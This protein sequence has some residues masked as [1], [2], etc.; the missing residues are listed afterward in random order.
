[1]TLSTAVE[2]IGNWDRDR[3]KD[4]SAMGCQERF[5]ANEMQ[6]FPPCESSVAKRHFAFCLCKKHAQQRRR[7]PGQRMFEQLLVNDGKP[8][9][10]LVPDLAT[11]WFR[12]QKVFLDK[13]T[14]KE[15]LQMQLT[16]QL[17]DLPSQFK[18]SVCDC[19]RCGCNEPKVQ[20]SIQYLDYCQELRR[21]REHLQRRR[22]HKRQGELMC[23]CHNP[24]A[25]PYAKRQ[26]VSQS[27]QPLDNEQAK[28]KPESELDL[29]LE[30]KPEPEPEPEG[31][32]KA[33]KITV[34]PTHVAGC[35]PDTSAERTRFT[36]GLSVRSKGKICHMYPQR[37][38]CCLR[39]RRRKSCGCIF[40]A[41][42]QPMGDECIAACRRFESPLP[43]LRKKYSLREVPQRRLNPACFRRISPEFYGLLKSYE[44]GMSKRYPLYGVPLRCWCK[45]T[46]CCGCEQPA[47]DAC[48]QPCLGDQGLEACVGYPAKKDRPTNDSKD[49]ESSDPIE[50]LPPNYMVAP[51]CDDDTCKVYKCPGLVCTSAKC[52]KNA[53]DE[54]CES[55]EQQSKAELDSNQNDQTSCPACS[56]EKNEGQTGE[57]HNDTKDSSVPNTALLS[58]AMLNARSLVS[59]QST[60]VGVSKAGPDTV[61][62]CCYPKQWFF[63]NKIVK[64]TSSCMGEEPELKAKRKGILGSVAGLCKRVI[65]P[66]RYLLYSLSTMNRQHVTYDDL[67]LKKP[68]SSKEPPKEIVEKAKSASFFS[69]KSKSSNWTPS[70][71][72]GT[73]WHSSASCSI[74]Q[75]KCNYLKR[76]PIAGQ[77]GKIGSKWMSANKIN[78]TPSFLPHRQKFMMVQGERPEWMTQSTTDI[79]ERAMETRTPDPT[80]EQPRNAQLVEASNEESTGQP[81]AV[82]HN[83]VFVSKMS[84]TNEKHSTSQ[85]AR[86]SYVPKT[87]YSQLM[88]LVARKRPK[89]AHHKRCAVSFAGKQR[90]NGRQPTNL[91]QRQQ[92][93]S[94][95]EQH[96]SSPERRRSASPV[97]NKKQRTINQG[98]TPKQIAEPVYSKSLSSV[99]YRTNLQAPSSAWLS[100][101]SDDSISLKDQFMSCE[102]Q[103]SKNRAPAHRQAKDIPDP[104]PAD[105]N[106]QRPADR[107]LQDKEYEPNGQQ[108]SSYTARMTRLYNANTS[109]GIGMQVTNMSE[110][111]PRNVFDSEEVYSDQNLVE[112]PQQHR[113]NGPSVNSAARNAHNVLDFKSNI[114]NETSMDTVEHNAERVA[115]ITHYVQGPSQGDLKMNSIPSAQQTESHGVTNLIF[116]KRAPNNKKIINL[117]DMVLKLP[118]VKV[119]YPHCKAHSLL[120]TRRP[121][122]PPSPPQHFRVSQVKM[123][124]DEQWRQLLEQA[125]L[126]YINQQNSTRM[127]RKYGSGRY[128]RNDND[129]DNNNGNNENE[130]ENY[131][132][133]HMRNCRS[134]SGCD[135]QFQDNDSPSNPTQQMSKTLFNN[136]T[137]LG[138]IGRQAPLPR[139]RTYASS[140]YAQRAKKI[141]T[142]PSGFRSSVTTDSKMDSSSQ[143]IKRFSSSEDVRQQTVQAE[144]QSDERLKRPPVE[145]YP[146][147]P[148]VMRPPSIL[149]SE[150]L[151]RNPSDVINAEYGNR[152]IVRMSA[153]NTIDCRD[154]EYV[155]TAGRRKSDM[156]PAFSESF[157]YPEPSR[158][159]SQSSIDYALPS[160]RQA[161][162]P[163]PSSILKS[164]SRPLSNML[165]QVA[166]IRHV[167]FMSTNMSDLIVPSREHRQAVYAEGE[168]TTSFSMHSGKHR[169]AIVRAQ[170]VYKNVPHKF[171]FM[172]PKKS[173]SI[174]SPLAEQEKMPSLFAIPTLPFTQETAHIG[175]SKVYHQSSTGH[176]RLSTRTKT[177]PKQRKLEE[178]RLPT[179]SQL[180]T[181][182]GDIPKMKRVAK[183]RPMPRSVSL[184]SDLDFNTYYT[185]ARH[186]TNIKNTDLPGTTTTDMSLTLTTVLD[187]IKHKCRGCSTNSCPPTAE[188]RLPPP[189]SSDDDED[190][191]PDYKRLSYPCSPHKVMGNTQ[192]LGED[193]YPRRRCCLRRLP[194]EPI[195]IAPTSAGLRM[196]QLRQKCLPTLFYGRRC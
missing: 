179:N 29:E 121:P 33:N 54:N 162:L 40:Q 61:Q 107:A 108:Y 102:S 57:S 36:G 195:V 154:V 137:T 68:K 143:K 183:D 180:L 115:N 158:R 184:F 142:A 113:T 94:S 18:P 73:L 96:E 75:N 30:P 190:S 27:D 56:Q 26:R 134:R 65:M 150:F 104:Q 146:K 131:N 51:D 159:H 13:V 11:D 127:G 118:K 172:Q 138:F 174:E 91:M 43:R 103:E 100:A 120:S 139:P 106:D 72:Q 64:D 89:T 191:E 167:N 156:L 128:Y 85:A 112:Q 8:E 69:S 9:R 176:K 148:A 17:E 31:S 169:P 14:S 164:A 126:N 186:I 52:Q 153:N 133:G 78:L 39:A 3:A 144:D 25:W 98:D 53:C 10:L 32:S 123:L 22:H 130:N 95:K 173:K 166:D 140:S 23:D 109:H 155:H 165:K 88:H 58:E 47:T 194:E 19:K 189:S 44:D 49:T 157:G 24:P 110:K 4:S 86:A 34:C 105:L 62:R 35:M 101:Y 196:Q 45:T 59:S 15:L 129:I 182:R 92:T 163:Q 81:E 145:R 2:A 125:N 63:K 70:Q 42:G 6:N 116:S 177:T 16:K 161:G 192:D 38:C 50:E 122:P 152:A 149:T 124:D 90:V 141:Y 79:D 171:S 193:N 132:N 99:Q 7:T 37:T 48:E 82:N 76:K 41:D 87:D 28:P 12:K 188:C 20:E 178:S 71:S 168:G 55:K 160:V 181:K 60:T 46:P 93:R 135:V 5:M 80:Q 175:N 111:C 1:M 147:K 97:P 114:S 84:R 136:P 67:S 151:G 77:F 66:G 74:V 187:Q 117:R 185:P 83:A 119:K 170:S 21:R